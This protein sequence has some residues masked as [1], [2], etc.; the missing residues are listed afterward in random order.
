MGTFVRAFRD[1]NAAAVAV[2]LPRYRLWHAMFGDLDEVWTEA[3]FDS[4]EAHI[5]AWDSAEASQEVM[6]A[7]GRM[8]SVCVPGTI[9]DYPLELLDA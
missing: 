6:A 1:L 4:L 3:E 7:A 9:H 5:R 2:G 8:V